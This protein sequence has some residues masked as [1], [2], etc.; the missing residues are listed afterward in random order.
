MSFIKFLFSKAFLRQLLIAIGI[1]VVLVFAI[2]FW[3]KSSTNHNQ[4]IRVP[5]L[6]KMS[7]DEAQ[8]KLD[9]LDLRFEILDS[10]NYNPDFPKYS[11]IEQIPKTG[12]FVKENRKIYLTLNRSGYVFL[13]IPEVVGKTR[14]QAEPTLLS[15]GFKIG[16]VSYKSYIALDEVLELRYKGKKI[17]PGDE[18]QKTSVIDLVL[19]D[20]EGSLKRNLEALD[21]QIKENDGGE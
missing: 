8:I 6:A 15:M 18:L 13:E 5:S 17:N 9:E 1:L 4:K 7:L 20:G 19:G 14:R 11:I 16:K 12:E 2:L 10:S 21:K 3:L